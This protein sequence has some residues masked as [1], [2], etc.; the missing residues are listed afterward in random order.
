[1]TKNNN[2]DLKTL[3]P[4]ILEKAND[5]IA[6][7]ESQYYFKFEYI[8]E[9]I[10]QRVLGYNNKDLLGKSILDII[11]PDDSRNTVSLFKGNINSGTN[12]EIIRIKNIE[13]NFKL[14][15][16]SVN[17]FKDNSD[18]NKLLIIL[19]DKS[20]I[21][22][23]ENE[24]EKKDS[25]YKELTQSIP[26]ISFWKL[27]YPKEYG[28]T[29]KISYTMLQMVIENIPENIFWKDK[30]LVY[31]GCNKNYAKLVG[32]KSTEDIIGKTDDNLFSDI[33]KLEK[34][35]EHETYALKNDTSI[36]H[37]IELW[38]S[39]EGQQIWLDTNRIPLHDFKGNSVGIL[40]SY[41]DITEKVRSEQEL[42]ESEEKFRT[43]TEL[44]LIGIIII[45]D[46]R[47]KYYNQH[48]ANIFGYK[49][50]ELK[51]WESN[52]FIKVVHL[53]DRDLVIDQSKI[54]QSEVT[55]AINKFQYRGIKKTGEIIW[56]ESYGR[57]IIFKGRSA[58]L[59]I[60]IDITDKIIGDKLLMESEKK[61]RTIT[62]ESLLGIFEYNLKNNDITYINPKLL[63]I[64]GYQKDDKLDRKNL[65]KRIYPEDIQTFYDS[66]NKND[67][68]F[69]IYD[70]NGKLKWLTGRKINHYDNKGKIESFRV[71]IEDV[72]EKK[73]YEKLIYE[74]NVN[75][76]NFTIDV[77]KNIQML[78]NTCRKLLN[79]E[80]VLYSHRSVKDGKEQYQVISGHDNLNSYDSDFFKKNLIVSE[81][82]QEN[83]DYTQ[84]FVD[85]DETKFVKTDNYIKQ[86]SAK[87][88][89]GKLIKSENE[90]NS[91]ICAF[92]KINPIISHEDSL[93]LF[94]ISD[95][96][97]IEQRRWQVYEY[98]EEQNKLKSELLSRTSHELKT[99]LISIKGFTDLLLKIHSSKLDT[100]VI[101]LLEEIKEG[102]RRLEEL[103]N[104]LIK[105]SRLDQGKLK[106][107]L[108][109]EDLSFLIKFCVR[110]LQG[111]AEI[112]NQK[113]V[114][115][116]HEYLTADF[117]K[118]RM[119]D[120]IA[121][122]L[123]NAIKYTPPNGEIII[124]SEIKEKFYIISIKD[125][126]IGITEEEKSQL[127]REFGKIERYGMGWDIG[128]EGSGLGLYMSKKIV[129]LHKGDMWVESEG[130]NKGSTFCFSLPII[131]E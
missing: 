102:S 50:E 81:L 77:Q 10:F 78:L 54:K 35:Q 129:Q 63:E 19:K 94:L 109:T 85:I 48:W 123:I 53:V 65:I 64:L 114:L 122:L 9:K 76:L 66:F 47:V 82:Y 121:N 120:V 104:S 45:Q 25:I 107:N 40:V 128:I 58:S 60:V 110:E 71:W 74:L 131:S 118:E 115:K 27:F 112:R 103:I 16:I 22:R 49:Y 105:S 125:T 14:F 42:K 43:I 30:D 72:T 18:R 87:G 55:D 80:I 57:S 113:I 79:A 15:E 8:N 34:F 5:L 126:G 88:C 67:L 91:A 108:T 62:E 99:P 59:N 52:D 95:A 23:L 51:N 111:L 38:D 83:H 12:L 17:S 70:K 84:T 28:D 69:R 4:L 119:Y 2:Y 117:D 75:F 32:L 1:M 37:N 89:I 97:E 7:I 13:N 46:D 26:E 86:Y 39:E 31:L 130:R 93:V 24:I 92:F 106:L 96:I 11:H 124:K 56:L 44:S 100:D 98:L 33:N 3:C 29:L 61:F 101:S 127:F 20:E 36:Y 73:S 6:I 41:Q 21:V 68:E 116:I 90:F